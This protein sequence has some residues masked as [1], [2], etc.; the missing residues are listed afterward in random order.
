[1]EHKQFRKLWSQFHW[2]GVGSSIFLKWPNGGIG[3]RAALKMQCPQ[4]RMGSSP[5][6]ATIGLVMELVY[7][8][9]SE[10]KALRG[11][12]VRVSP[13]SQMLACWNW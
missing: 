12:R 8:F 10:A 4:G 1:M 5:F 7:I 3:R 6:L 13:R 2:L 11:V 9:V